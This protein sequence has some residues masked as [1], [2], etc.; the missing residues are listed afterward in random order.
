MQYRSLSPESS[1]LVRNF[2]KK[3]VD[4]HDI[5]QWGGVHVGLEVGVNCLMV[6]TGPHSLVLEATCPDYSPV[7]L[8][9][10]SKTTAKSKTL[11]LLSM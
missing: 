2:A 4:A 3:H 10:A 8:S 6:Q 11:D 7:L 5:L 1:E 9:Q